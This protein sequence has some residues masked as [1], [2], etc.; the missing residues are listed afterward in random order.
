MFEIG[1]SWH[2]LQMILIC[3][4]TSARNI[5]ATMQHHLPPAP[6]SRLRVVLHWISALV[7]IWATC[8]G[9]FAVAHA[10]SSPV[11]QFIDAINP[12]L[13]TLFIPLFA[14]RLGLYV[15]GQ[16]WR[17]WG[18]RLA[19]EQAAAFGH[20]LLYLCITLVL[21]SGLFI[22]P[23]QWMLLGILPIPAFIHNQH[24]LA[25][26]GAAHGCLCAFLALL[27]MGHVS[28]VL[29]HQLSGHPVLSR[30]MFQHR[31]VYAGSNNSEIFKEI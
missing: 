6:Y 30:M 14:L 12:Q 16:P 2:I 20:G 17:A 8:S 24:D 31:G 29:W 7:I 19:A 18:D 10:P 22:M 9:F 5:L 28:A 26:L 25:R 4:Y 13:T 27:I 21:V 1:V 15:Q 3:D 11:R 23:H